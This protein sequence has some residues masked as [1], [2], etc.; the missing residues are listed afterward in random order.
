V[1]AALV[2]LGRLGVSLWIV[3]YLSSSLARQA[4]QYGPIGV[5]FAIFS[6]LF[7]VALTTLAGTLV[8]AVVTA[9]RGGAAPGVRTAS[10]ASA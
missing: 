1:A 8:A 2:A 3:A 7:A 5:V 6:G 9:E 10:P 4:E